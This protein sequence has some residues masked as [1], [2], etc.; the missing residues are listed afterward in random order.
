M[1][2]APRGEVCVELFL[3]SLPVTFALFYLANSLQ[4][5]FVAW[6]RHAVRTAVVDFRLRG[7]AASVCGSCDG[8][9][10]RPGVGPVVGRC[11]TCDGDGFTVAAA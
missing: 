9:G 4:S 7:A 8:T 6:R 3:A 1:R 11:E 5:I 10:H 2:Y